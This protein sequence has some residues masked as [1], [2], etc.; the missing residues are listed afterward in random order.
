MELVVRNDEFNP[1]EAGTD[2][3]TRRFVVGSLSAALLAGNH[4]TPPR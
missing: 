4:A 2:A 3:G 1:G